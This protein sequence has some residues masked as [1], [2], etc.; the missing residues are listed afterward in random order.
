ML[1]ALPI[2][3]AVPP[4]AASPKSARASP[5]GPYCLRAKAVRSTTS[6]FTVNSCLLLA[7]YLLASHCTARPMSCRNVL[8]GPRR[9]TGT[10]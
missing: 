1:P 10:G 9:A 2:C 5:S 8:Y 6:A 3:S 4:Q 7:A